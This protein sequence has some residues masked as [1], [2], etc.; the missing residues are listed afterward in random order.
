MQRNKFMTNYF[1]C[2]LLWMAS[3]FLIAHPVQAAE[4]LKLVDNPNVCM[5]T[6]MHF[7]KKQIP[8]AHAGKTYYG[9]CENCKKTL[10]EDPK[11]RVARDPVSGKPVDKALA[12]IGSR[13]DN[14]VVYFESKQ[15]VP[16]RT[17][18]DPGLPPGLPA[19]PLAVSSQCFFSVY[20]SP[21]V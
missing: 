21:N 13:A 19:H 7:G 16:C 12:I 6:D 18:L 5:V 4:T 14:S 3:L 17:L 15:I 2:P 1:L 20:L 8:V 10:T 9:C 11:A